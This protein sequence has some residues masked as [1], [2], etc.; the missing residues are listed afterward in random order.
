MT[1]GEGKYPGKQRIPSDFNET[2]L[3]EEILGGKKELF[4]LLVER[5]Q[6]KVHAM[7]L[8]FFHNQEDAA[9]FT[10]DVFLRSYRSLAAFRGQARLSTWLYRIA[11]NTAVNNI[12]RR[13]EYHSLAEE[14]VTEDE[15][16]EL[17]ILR[18]AAQEAV[19]SAVAELPEKYRVCVDL[20]FFYDCSIREIG[21]I[22]G[23]PENTIKSHVFR[24]K[25]L[26]REKL[27]DER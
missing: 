15:S 20:Y 4:R 13:K 11:Y 1:E 5:Y 24:G 9:D 2:L 10:Q 27:A 21:D 19:R 3:V 17:H 8:S 22:T 16:P 23:F 14:P 18:I 12:N 6:Q 25:K 26:L 7:G